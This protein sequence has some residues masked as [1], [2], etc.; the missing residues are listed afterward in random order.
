MIR[1]QGARS[2]S[3]LHRL[4]RIPKSAYPHLVGK[5]GCGRAGVRIVLAKTPLGWA[6]QCSQP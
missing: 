1:G 4:L 2:T 6:L 5:I 3:L